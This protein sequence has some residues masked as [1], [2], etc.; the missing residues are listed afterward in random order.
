[1]RYRA[2]RTLAV[3]V[4]RCY[5]ATMQRA[6]HKSL[7]S[8][9]T[10]SLIRAIIRG[11][12]S[13]AS[14]LVRESPLL[15]RQCLSAGATRQE[16]VDFFFKEIQHYMYAGDTPLH[17]AAAAYRKDIARVLLQNGAEVDARNRKGAEP[18]HYAADGGLGSPSWN[19]QAQAATIVL[20]IEAGANPNAL[21]KSGVAPLHRAVRQRCPSAVDALLRNGAEVRLKNKSGSTPLHLAVQTTGRGGTGAPESK[22]CQREIIQILLKSGASS[23]DQDARG[24]TVRQSAQGDWIRALL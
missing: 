18:L 16:A 6:L 12:A 1:M 4:G 9:P 20:L 8:L 23:Q 15:V 14:K 22:A 7:E 11:D 24:R 19:P 5:L 21:D 17:A 2:E 3:A 13:E 10:L